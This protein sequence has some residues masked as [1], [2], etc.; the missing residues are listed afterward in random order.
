ME[1]DNIESDI[2]ENIEKTQET[3][4]TLKDHQLALFEKCKYVEKS[5]KN[6]RN[7]CSI[8]EMEDESKQSENY[9]KEIEFLKKTIER[10][11]SEI[12]KLQKKLDEAT[13]CSEES[14]ESTTK[15]RKIRD[16]E[17]LINTTMIEDSSNKDI[18]IT[19]LE[20]ENKQM[21]LQI[22][23]LKA[24]EVIDKRPMKT[25]NED[26]M[27]SIEDRLS[28]GI[29]SIKA[30]LENILLK[31][32]DDHMQNTSNQIPNYAAALK[33]S[34][35]KQ[36]TT[37][38]TSFREIARIAKMEELEEENQKRIRQNNIIIH[39]K[40]EASPQSAD[41]SGSEE[42]SLFVREMLKE[43]CIGAVT[44]KSM[45]RIGNKNSE[46]IRPLK[47]T[48]NNE[49]DKAK[50]FG[51]LKNLKG[52]SNY[53][54][55]SIKEDFTISERSIIREYVQRANEKNEKE[56]GDSEYVWRV[57][58]SPKNRLFLKKVMKVNQKV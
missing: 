24:S 39:G 46:K 42:D 55:I 50:V 27:K 18:E 44:A 22:E 2:T 58:G 21:K 38:V 25:T 19:T 9:K 47:V 30:E 56:A 41:N 48:F 49:S 8:E 23:K 35:E 28:D 4:R 29:Q 7:D 12:I 53:N 13:N 11:A 31:R 51:N 1:S 6:S 36:N 5:P 10:Q 20:E 17:S 32:L 14:V 34:T 15:K 37:S 52:K 40:K 33:E 54:G 3:R 16:V 57:R 43:L 45:E 26:F